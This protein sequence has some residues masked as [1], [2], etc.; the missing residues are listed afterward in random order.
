MACDFYDIAFLFGCTKYSETS[1]NIMFFL[2]LGKGSKGTPP[3]GEPVNPTPLPPFTVEAETKKKS[4]LKKSES[5][6]KTSDPETEQLLGSD[7]QS[8][9]DSV[10]NSATPLPSRKRVSVKTDL[11]VVR[12]SGAGSWHPRPRPTV[13]NKLISI[14]P[15]IRPLNPFPR[16]VTTSIP[17]SNISSLPSN[18]IGSPMPSPATPQ[19]PPSQLTPGAP[20]SPDDELCDNEFVASKE[21]QTLG[22]TTKSK[23]ERNREQINNN[24]KDKEGG[25]RISQDD[26]GIGCGTSLEILS[27]LGAGPSPDTGPS[28][29]PTLAQLN[30]AEGEFS[31]ADSSPTEESKLLTASASGPT[32]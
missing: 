6:S 17:K 32:S 9:S 25:E 13:P 8:Y 5:V 18:G 20:L 4:I 12:L 3:S 10:S 2:T 14:P 27:G 21:I 1:I 11:G 7:N 28:P 26:S 30:R 31:F 24:H 19:T 15:L 16:Q 22:F 23:F 29:S